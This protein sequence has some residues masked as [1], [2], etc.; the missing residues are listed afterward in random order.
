M[1]STK[2]P[3]HDVGQ[4]VYDQRFRARRLRSVTRMAKELG[5]KLVPEAT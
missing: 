1:L 5:F 4:A 3:Y 2:R